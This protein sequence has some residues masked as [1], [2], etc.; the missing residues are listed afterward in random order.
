MVSTLRRLA[1]RV[2]HIPSQPSKMGTNQNNFPDRKGDS[3]DLKGL[4]NWSKGQDRL[5]M[6]FLQIFLLG[7]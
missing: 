2:S 6:E 7:P 4:F 3:H 1:K 5:E